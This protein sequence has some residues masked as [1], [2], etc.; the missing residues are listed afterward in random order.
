MKGLAELLLLLGPLPVS[1]LLLSL[2]K[3]EKSLPPQAAFAKKRQIV[4]YKLERS[5]RAD[6]ASADFVGDIIFLVANFVRR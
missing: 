2:R 5:G 6:N 3:I 4:R 1:K